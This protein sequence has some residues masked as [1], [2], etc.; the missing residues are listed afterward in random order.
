MK[1]NRT[2]VVSALLVAAPFVFAAL[3][4]PKLPEQMPMR[5]GPSGQPASFV[6]KPVGALFGPLL[7]VIISVVFLVLDRAA[8]ARA[9]FATSQRTFD[10]L[11][12][13]FLA[14]TLLLTVV[15]QLAAAGASNAVNQYIPGLVGLLFVVLGNFMGKLTQNYFIGI[16][17]PWT[18]SSKEVWFKTHRLAGRLF[19]VCGLVMVV[20]ST[21]RAPIAIILAAAAMAAVIP[22]VYSY[23]LHRRQV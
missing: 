23:L 11:K 5:W 16:R 8:T 20:A 2:Q 18:L 21:V 19:V 17:T 7:S 1:L 4:Y 9:S 13:T 3:M 15:T 10:V 12:V 6:S 14:F 22:V